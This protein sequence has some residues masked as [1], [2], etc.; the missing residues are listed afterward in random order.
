VCN[1]HPCIIR[2][3]TVAIKKILKELMKKMGT[4][5]VTY[6]ASYFTTSRTDLYGLYSTPEFYPIGEPSMAIL[7]NAYI[8]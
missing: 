3:A 5:S 4:N 2:E 6:G 8:H 1:Y 7:L